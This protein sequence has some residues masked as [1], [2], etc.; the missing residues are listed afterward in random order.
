[1]DQNQD[2]EN[3][4]QFDQIDN[5]LSE[6]ESRDSKLQTIRQ[7]LRDLITVDSRIR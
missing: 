3:K 2:E 7:E 4:E 5:S 1:M 6:F